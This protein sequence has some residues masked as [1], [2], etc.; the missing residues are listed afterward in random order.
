MI[1]VL[2]ILSSKKKKNGKDIINVRI[3]FKLKHIF[4]TY[5]YYKITLKIHLHC[6]KIFL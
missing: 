5:K 6:L 3:Y 2:L 4:P 1:I